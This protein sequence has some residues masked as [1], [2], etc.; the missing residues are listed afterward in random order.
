[1]QKTG[2]GLAMGTVMICLLVPMVPFLLIGGALVDRLDPVRLMLYSDIVRCVMTALLAYLMVIDQLEVWHVYVFATVFGFI[3]AF[4]YP[5]S[6]KV[7]QSIV[8][9]DDLPSANSL[10]AISQQ[11]ATIAGPMGAAL[12]ISLGQSS[13]AFAVD[14]AT[15]AIS[16]LCLL[17]LLGRQVPHETTEQTS[18][19]A[20]VREGMGYVRREPWLWVSILAFLV[21]NATS[22]PIFAIVVPYIIT[23]VNHQGASV[24]AIVE[25][26]AA[27][28]TVA[29]AF[30][31]GR[32]ERLSRRG[33]VIYGCVI[34]EG[35][36][37]IAFGLPISTY[38]LAALAAVVGV[39]NSV[40]MLAWT[41][42]MQERVPAEM[43]GRV[44]SIDWASAIVTTPIGMAV[45]GWGVDWMH[46][47]AICAIAGGLGI[48][49]GLLSLL[50]PKIREID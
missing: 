5:A 21:I 43:Y 30:W 39:G 3:S 12:I 11:T 8:P 42:L 19:V 45:I 9:N 31:L 28:G 49:A 1:M 22:T 48:L 13:L 33:I 25:S 17:P 50:H 44:S 4:F 2:S 7:Q 15:F 47:L 41:N 14:A 20:D 18:V 34:I 40:I 16:A 26:F 32:R 36:V 46:P 37:S 29:A 23:Q 24:L 6:S 10:M 35:V 38:G 27:A